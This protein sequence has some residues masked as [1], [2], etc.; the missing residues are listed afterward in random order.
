MWQRPT[1]NTS[2]RKRVGAK[3]FR[4]DRITEK[5][6]KFIGVYKTP[7]SQSPKTTRSQLA[8]SGKRAGKKRDH[9]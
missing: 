3:T 8:I 5:S 2:A 1:E 9:H 6:L 4:I 7:K